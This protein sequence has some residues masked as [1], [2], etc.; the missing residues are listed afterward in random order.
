MQQVRK[1]PSGQL[2]GAW[3]RFVP[4]RRS[5]GWLAAALFLAGSVWLGQGQGLAAEHGKGTSGGACKT[6]LVAKVQ[7]EYQA[8]ES[9]EASFEQEDHRGDG[10]KGKASGRV[11]YR[12]PGRM[13]WEYAPPN[14]QLL[15][16]DGETVWLFDPLLENVTVHPLEGL[17]RGTPLA[18]LLGA[19]NLSKDFR[20]MPFTALPPRDGLTYLELHPRNP[21]PGLA[22]IQ[23]GVSKKGAA[24]QVLRMVDSQ[25][26]IRQIR[27]ENLRT[28]AVF[29]PGHFTFKIEE[30]MEVIT[31]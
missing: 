27:F 29:P 15:V 16:T 6:G 3:R 28:G 11:A 24:I 8:I 5:A 14:E 30:G 10:S 31:K 22:Y 13:R 25:K 12:R 21:I 17:T 19:G 7:R 9:F 1:I 20:C 26:N 23:L 18:F 4:L 2:R